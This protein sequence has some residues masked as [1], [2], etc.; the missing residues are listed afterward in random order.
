MPSDLRASS[1]SE[2]YRL[3]NY[4]AQLQSRHEAEM[5]ALE[6]RHS[7]E[8]AKTIAAQSEAKA[9][10]E[11]DFEVHISQEA[12]ELEDKLAH[13][14]QVSAER[15]E[16]E[17]HRGEEELERTRRNNSDKIEQYK[18]NAESQLDALRKQSQ[19]SVDNLHEK[20]RKM[21]RKDKEV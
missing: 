16:S 11:K 12:G 13:V 19:A 9:R 4:R 6:E 10:L 15:L 1:A 2:E 18:K 20:T 14:R 21:A 3:S 7:E 8:M 5:H 17:K